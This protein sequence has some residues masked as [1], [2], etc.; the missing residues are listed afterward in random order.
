[1]YNNHSLTRRVVPER[2]HGDSDQ[3]AVVQRTQ[4]SPCFATGPLGLP[5]EITPTASSI[6]NCVRIS[7]GT[8]SQHKKCQEG[9]R[10][11]DKNTRTERGGVGGG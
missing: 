4:Q 6:K 11:R 3:N 10:E 2:K 9:E 7:I 1:M 8:R 5:M